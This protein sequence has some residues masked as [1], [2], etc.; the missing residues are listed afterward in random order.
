MKSVLAIALVCG[1][2]VSANAAVLWDQ[3]ALGTADVANQEFGDFPAFNNYSVGDIAVTGLG[4]Q[5][6]SV[7]IFVS[8]QNA[9]AW[10]AQVTQGR[11]NIFG[12]TGGTPLASDDP[13]AG[14]LVSISTTSVGNNVYKITASGLN[15]NVSAGNYWVGLTPR[16]DF[17]AVGQ[18]FH[19]NSTTTSGAPSYWRNPSGGFGSGS[20]WIPASTAGNQAA[21]VDG[22][23]MI[24]GTQVVPEP[25]TMAALA[26]GAV[27]LLRRRKK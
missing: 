7:S 20:D 18:A 10:Q 8:L 9:T 15:M 21:F 13:T 1:S 19:L 25:G 2:V 11:L 27:A 23:L 17:G 12:K 24:E 22:S 26:I 5:I 6:T 16:G 14:S 3:S 4:W